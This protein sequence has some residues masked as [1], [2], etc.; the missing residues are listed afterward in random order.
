MPGTYSGPHQATRRHRHVLDNPNR[1]GPGPG[2]TGYSPGVRLSGL[3]QAGPLHLPVAGHLSRLHR[4]DDSGAGVG[5]VNQAIDHAE[6]AA[7]AIRALNHATYGPWPS[8]T[9][10]A[11][12]G[13]VDVTLAYLSML[14]HRLPQALT[15]AERWL[16]RALADGRVRHD[17]GDDPG[18]AVAYAAESL[19]QARAAAESL[20]GHLDRAH[21]A[22]SHLGGYPEVDRC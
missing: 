12:P 5:P 17:T 6:A 22:T 7:E 11:Q 19:A 14:A 20:A 8:A 21:T 1:R 2:G 16:S 3:C 13:D 4:A 15:W 10:Y 9:G 18:E